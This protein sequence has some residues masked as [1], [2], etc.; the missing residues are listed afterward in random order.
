MTPEAEKWFYCHSTSS[1]GSS[2]MNDLFGYNPDSKNQRD[3]FR[4]LV[5]QNN[6][7]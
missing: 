2:S 5:S 3:Y 6:N 7:L 4:P 1:L